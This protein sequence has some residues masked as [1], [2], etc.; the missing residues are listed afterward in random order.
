MKENQTMGTV[1]QSPPNRQMLR[2]ALFLMALFG[3]AAFLVLLA[4]LYQLQILEHDRYEQL[5]VEQQLRQAPSSTARGI[6]YDTNM[7]ALA[8]SASVD[9]VYLSPAEIELYGEDKALIARE[10]AK[11]LDLDEAELLQKA[12]QTGSWYVTVA[13]KVEREQADQVRQLKNRYGLRGVRLETDTKRYYPNSTLA[14]H[15]I[16][17][18]GTDNYGLEGIEARYDSYLSG[19]AGRTVRA[20]NAFGTDLL[21]AQFEEYQPGQDGY[22]IVTTIDS[23]IQYYVEK[24]LKQAVQDYDIQN[25]AGAIAMDVNTGAVL[26]MASLDNYDLNHFLDV[27]D[28]AREAID[29]AE[30][31]D[32]A[33]ALLSAAQTRQWRNKAL[34]D[35]YEPGSTF[36]IITLSM[37]LEEGA[38]DLNSSFYCGG[39]VSVKGRTS[40]I[41]CWKDGGHGSQDLTQAVQHSCNVAFVNIGQRIGAEAFYRYCEAFGFLELSQDPDV[42]LTATTG[43]DLAGE[44]G[45]IWWSQNT[46]CSQKNLS[47]LAAASF[48]QTFTITPLQL[49][50]AVSACVNGGYLMQPY[51]VREMLNPDGTLAYERKPTL[52]RQVISE[53]TSAVVRGILEQVVGDPNDGTGRNAAVAGYRIGGKTGTSE[54]VSLE[55]Q[56]G[57]KEYIVSFIGF[58]PA[59]DPK[60]AVLIFLDTPSN[61]S[62]VYVSGGQMAAPVVGRMM[63]DILPYLGVEPDLSQEEAANMDVNMPSL[64]GLSLHEAVDRLNDSGLRYR[65]IGAGDVVTGQLPRAGVNIAGG[66]Q[67]ILYLDAQA[68]ADLETVPELSGMTYREARDALSYYGL[69]IQTASPVT[70]AEDQLVSSQSI[71]AGTALE[72][73]AVISVS[74]I[75]G[76]ESMLGKY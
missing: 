69:Y 13:R 16:G 48:G 73:G 35:T 31:A 64:S 72:H 38:V 39:N 66:T 5:A 25:G 4:R 61:A 70:D 15:L 27:S 9:N 76:D 34:S 22:D 20:T 45:S 46:F 3:I 37:A 2:R 52:R 49:I 33:Q 41:R 71:P 65:T 6:I 60:I 43:I 56:T 53:E 62:G 42:N 14:C 40:P 11:I 57:V 8:I 74:L 67:V 1:T 28:E 36:K 26:A 32:Q 12:S 54:K 29:T 30:D 19:T 17:F 21:F 50:T 68:S 7:N 18:V 63:A 44:S 24:H 58:A 59:D 47:Q 23:T 75:S 55:A 10:L 51:V